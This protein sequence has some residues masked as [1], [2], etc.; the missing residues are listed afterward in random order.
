MSLVGIA[1]INNHYVA[2]GNGRD[3]TILYDAG[4]R[5][6]RQGLDRVSKHWPKAKVMP[7]KLRR[8]PGLTLGFSARIEAD[9]QHLNTSKPSHRSVFE[10][11]SK[12]GEELDMR[13]SALMMSTPK[14]AKSRSDPGL[15]NGMVFE[16]SRGI[17]A[18]MAKLHEVR[19]STVPE[20]P[21][22]KLLSADEMRTPM[23]E[24][25]LAR[26]P[27]AGFARTSYGGYWPN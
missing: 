5:A 19:P 18:S 7:A 23:W 17:S 1:R 26:N 21:R 20:V 2:D 14:L 22:P 8:P 13:A 10:A 12:M 16:R 11:K 15:T 24:R 6:G 4:Y 25:E 9:T 3:L 27:Y